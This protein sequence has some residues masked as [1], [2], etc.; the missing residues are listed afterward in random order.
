MVDVPMASNL[1]RATEADIA[2]YA[3][4]GA[5]TPDSGQMLNAPQGA[6]EFVAKQVFEGSPYSRKTVGGLGVVGSA[7]PAVDIGTELSD[8]EGIVARAGQSGNFQGLQV[9]SD[10]IRTLDALQKTA[11]AITAM[12]AD[13]NIPMYRIDSGTGKRVK[14]APGE[15]QIA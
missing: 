13:K 14:I 9:Q 15:A 12:A 3:I 6:T 1:P 8:F 4:S 10:G 2:D 7:M 5:N 11:D